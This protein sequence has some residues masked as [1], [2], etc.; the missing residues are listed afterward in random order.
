MS[1]AGGWYLAAYEAPTARIMVCDRERVYGFGRRPQYFP[2]TTALEYH[3]FSAEK[4]P[5]IV[6]VN[7]KQKR[8]SQKG[9]RR[10]IP[11]RPVY[12]WS[13][14]APVLGRALVLAGDTL[15]VAG[16]PDVVN[17]ETTISSLHTAETAGLLADQRDAYAGKKGGVLLAVSATDGSR[18]AA[19][20]L[21]SIPVF[22]GMAAAHESLFLTATDG[23]VLCLAGRGDE[24]L[25]TASGVEVT[26]T[27]TPA[28][29]SGA[30]APL[31][32][33]AKHPDF[34]HVAAVQ[35]MP[36]KLGWRLKAPSGKVGLAL[37][38]L[39]KPITARTTFTLRFLMIPNPNRNPGKPAPGN[40]FLAFGTGPTDAALIKCGLRSAGQSG[41]IVEGPLAS[42]TIT[43]HKLK[44]NVNEVIEM[45]VTV[46]PQARTVKV[47]VLG[48]TFEATLK[49][50]LS[51][52]S[53][54][55]Y[56]VTSVASEFGPVTQSAAT[57]P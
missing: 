48:E 22:D 1:A 17:Q 7:P 52:I 38:A 45:A 14:V 54:V 42:G 9:R 18:R 30:P 25:A 5:E 50:P 6:P 21:D 35:I 12:Q 32:L 43:T 11:T 20:Q 56:V 34:Q 46:D 31:P 28:P 44:V 2:R 8:T 16:P 27:P 36:C 15:F 24:D 26:D 37:R 41:S 4:E 33:T 3:I 10:P 53:H 55:G 39:E 40:A 13:R 47:D 49:Q 51:E 29:T 23:S 19:Y 57:L